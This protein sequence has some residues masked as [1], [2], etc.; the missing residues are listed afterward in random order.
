[1]SAVKTEGTRTESPE[2]RRTPAGRVEALELVARAVEEID[3]GSVVI[4][5]HQGEVVAIET[6]TKVRVKG[7]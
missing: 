7:S 6:S 1:V 3:Y 4:T 2:Q 5:I